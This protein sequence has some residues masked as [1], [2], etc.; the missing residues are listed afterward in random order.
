MVP[1]QVLVTRPFTV[2]FLAYDDRGLAQV[3]VSGE[4]TG[5]P[6]LDEGQT[7]MCAGVTCQG[8]WTLTW[9]QEA[10]VSLTLTALALDTAGLASEPATATVLILPGE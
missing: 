1:S 9:T 4:E 8:T 7:F 6:D 10:S 2:S 5:D 3:L